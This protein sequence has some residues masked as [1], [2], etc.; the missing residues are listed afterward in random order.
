[1]SS[2]FLK[3]RWEDL[4][5]AN[6]VI[7]P[8]VLEKYVPPGTE[9]DLFEGKCYVS[10]VAFMF[11]ETKVLGLKFPG[12]INFEEVNLRFYVKTPGS[13]PKRGV[14]FIK[15]IVPKSLITLV[16]NSLYHENYITL[17]MKHQ[18]EGNNYSDAADAA[19][20]RRDAR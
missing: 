17:K 2:P 1:M 10:L 3:A 14:C 20:A 13:E 6:Y 5:L 12:H 15:E 8:Q 4:I 11:R 7:D 9:L 16:A 19:T 18:H